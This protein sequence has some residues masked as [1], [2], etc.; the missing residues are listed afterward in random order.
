MNELK[1]RQKAKDLINN[2]LTDLEELSI[3]VGKSVPTIR[4][5]R[6]NDTSVSLNTIVDV[7]NTL[8]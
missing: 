5:I 3:V 1:I 2:R 8:K 4:K 7:I 6:N